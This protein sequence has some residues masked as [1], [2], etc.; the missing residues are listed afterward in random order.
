MRP[1]IRLNRL[2]LPILTAGAS[3]LLA[4]CGPAFAVLP[5]RGEPEITA[6]APF[7][8]TLTAFANQ[9]EGDPYDLADYV[10]PIAVEL[11]NDSQYEVRICYA[12]FALRDD[13]GVRHQ[14]INPYVP[15]AL[16]ALEQPVAEKPVLLAARGGGVSIGAPSGMRGGGGGAVRMSAPHYLGGRGVTIGAP[17]GRRHGYGG[18]GHLHR[19]G[20]FLFYGGAGF[21]GPG[22]GYWNGPLFYPPFYDTWVI[23]WGP[24]V[25][26]GPWPWVRPSYDVLASGLPEGVLKPGAS[27]SGFLYFRKATQPAV[28]TLD[29]G[30]DMVDVRTNRSLG[31]THVPLD[32]VAR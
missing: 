23:G 10:T 1:S 28:H 5:A 16:G 18:W 29:L 9:W 11:V 22:V 15:A 14:A 20:G 17:V 21:W 26:A 31:S 19:R 4:G 6:S 27:I 30:W 25:Y 32:V 7:G 3:A 24:A 2:L 8:I 13:H 12:D